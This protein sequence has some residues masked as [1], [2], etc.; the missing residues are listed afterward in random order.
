VSGSE[1]QH[2]LMSIFLWV[3]AGATLG[4]IGHRFLNINGDRNAFMV[5]AIGGFGGLLGGM[6]IA[7]ML[8]TP[9]TNPDAF[10]IGAMG[11]ALLVAAAVLYAGDFV[12][13]RYKV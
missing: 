11:F 6:V 4:W 5:I 7:P 12:A 9:A 8:L 3:L 2:P 10:S 1:P 13:E